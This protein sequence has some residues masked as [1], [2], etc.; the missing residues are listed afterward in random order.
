MTQREAYD[1]FRALHERGRAFIMP[2]AW[3]AAS[4]AIFADAGFE[5]LGST[6]LAI[7]FSLGR[8]D[9]LRAVS[10][11]EAIANAGLLARVSELPV[12]G[13]LEDG[14]GEAP[15]DCELT[16]EAAVA[17]GLAGLG[18]EDTTADPLRPIHDFD[19]AVARVAAAAKRAKGRI[20]L[21]A[22]TDN[23]LHGR[24]DLDDTIRRLTA[25]AD[26]GADVL[27]APALP[28]QD[29]VRAVVRAVAPKPLNVLLGPF[30]G[31]IPLAELDALGAV[32]ISIGGAA[33]LRAMG[34]VKTT[35]AKLANGD[36]SA[37]SG[38]IRSGD[39]SRLFPTNMD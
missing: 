38:G 10:R 14:F 34:E 12:N 21:T 26:V 31:F 8:V 2:N 7:A 23:F 24:P 1:R 6:S 32:R 18:I 35:A 9:G 29:A 11:E 28:D 25:F 22:R 3:D 27:Y 19:D 36:L 20:V 5:A 13:D 39:I 4:A 30:D 16:V 33:Y 15:E 37:A 17:G